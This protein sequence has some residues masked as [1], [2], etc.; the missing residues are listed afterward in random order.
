M[1]DLSLLATPGGVQGLRGAGSSDEP[2]DSQEFCQMNKRI[3]EEEHDREPQ[4]GQ[5][6]CQKNKRP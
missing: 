3:P 6:F 5:E 1:D 2:Q 4:G